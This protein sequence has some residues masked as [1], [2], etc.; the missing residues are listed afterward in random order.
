VCQMGFCELEPKVGTCRCGCGDKTP[1]ASQTDLRRNWVQGKPIQ[2]IRFH[3][4]KIICHYS[5]SQEARQNMAKAKIG[6]K[7]P[8]WRGD[9][10]NDISARERAVRKFPDIGICEICKVSPAIDRHH[11]DKN[12]HHN[13][14]KNLLFLCRRCHMEEDKRLGYLGH[15]PREKRR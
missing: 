2:F 1:L 4:N 3:Q 13:E 6:S 12:T 14:R 15:Y 7:N 11:K 8:N 9:Q 5:K 10:T